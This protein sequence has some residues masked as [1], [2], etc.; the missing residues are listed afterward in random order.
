VETNQR[1]LGFPSLSVVD[2][3]FRQCLLEF[4]LT[5]GSNPCAIEVQDFEV[6]QSPKVSQPIVCHRSKAK[7]QLSKSCQPFQVL[8]TAVYYVNAL[9]IQFL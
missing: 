4:L 9:K 8:Q 3:A 7:I 5:T 1:V 6:R 2:L